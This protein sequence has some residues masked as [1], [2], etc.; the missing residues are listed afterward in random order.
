MKIFYSTSKPVYKLQE[1]WKI[2]CKR[3]RC[4]KEEKGDVFASGC[5]SISEQFIQLFRNTTIAAFTCKNLE[6]KTETKK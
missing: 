1:C 5:C 4:K 3:R 2:C 6:R